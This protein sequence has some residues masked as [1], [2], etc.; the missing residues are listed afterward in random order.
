[1]TTADTRR[2]WPLW[3]SVLLYGA[4]AVAMSWPLSRELG[5][6]V[7]NDPGDPLLNTWIV[8]W[9]SQRVPL[10]ESWWNAGIYHPS[11]G[12]L[13]FSETLL[14]LA[15]I[16]SPLLWLGASPVTVYNLLFLGSF[17]ASAAAADLLARELTGRADAGLL[18]GLIYGF[19][20]YRQTQL[21]HI[22]V[23]MSAGIPLA[24][25]ALHRY[26]RTRQ[27]RWLA[28]FVAAFV[29]QGLA[30]GYYLFFL[31]VLVV[32]WWLWF[33][34]AGNRR[35]HARFA[36]ACAACAVFV[37]PVLLGYQRIQKHYGFE[38]PLA[39][40]K[41]YSADIASVANADPR[42]LLW[43]WM[44]FDDNPE[45]RLFP[46]ALA[47]AIVAGGVLLAL[48]ARPLADPR[49]PLLRRLPRWL[50]GLAIVPVAAATWTAT[51]GG[52][53]LQAGPLRLSSSSADKPLSLA[54]LLLI[55]AG[56]TSARARAAWRDRSAFGFYALAGVA[57]W[58]LALGPEPHLF[59]EP[60]IY[61]AP[62]WW[63]LDVPGF[64]GLRVPARFITLALVCLSVA[65]AL[66]WQRY[67]RAGR[68]GWLLAVPAAAIVAL[69]G[70]S[71]PFVLAA[72][73]K[74][75][76]RLDT[77]GSGAVLELPLSELYGDLEA[78]YHSMTHA[79]PTVNGYSGYLPPSYVALRHAFELQECEILP[80]L[81][82]HGPLLVIV[83][84]EHDRDHDWR[85][86]VSACGGKL[87]ASFPS[88]SIYRLERSADSS[89]AR[90]PSDTTSLA[91]S[92]TSASGGAASA[93]LA[94]DGRDDTR[95]ATDGAQKSD[96]W[97]IV[98]LARPA[99][100]DEI[101]LTQGPWVL[102]YPR[103]LAVDIDTEDGAWREAWRGGLSVRAFR[104]LLRTPRALAVRLPLPGVRATRLRL[105]QLA[106]G[107]SAAWSVAEVR[108][109]GAAE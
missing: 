22:Q 58:V 41:N 53:S 4:L 72:L 91:V 76:P 49:S 52:W 93:L 107:Q 25:F 1:M 62:Y 54:L 37:L 99:R 10:T 44:A 77:F 65:A 83:R 82:S 92:R 13:A 6:V 78:V 14:G 68:R 8:W 46:G 31:S 73:P 23:L 51:S 40:I 15:P 39:E 106:S 88:S 85:D 42:S 97:L 98:E 3:A 20:P 27:R 90:T 56:L 96:D 7:P 12:T 43:R 74:D 79:R 60:M 24:L 45:R 71:S 69:E 16:A 94:V 95:W 70:W 55:L 17:V 50:L 35:D 101:E 64:K 18:A 84:H 2:R 103:V 47:V 21:G 29:W 33:G 67:V 19:S 26:L 57:L 102:D 63:L 87:Q 9:N 89:V 105:R 81:A 28:I 108:V 80:A 38:R 36:V 100:V 32:L 75:L 104:T 11:G 59:G 5:N 34:R 30:N 66:V 86:F 109:R 48:I 61:R